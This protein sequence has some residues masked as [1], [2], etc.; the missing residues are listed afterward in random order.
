MMDDRSA[1]SEER[2]LREPPLPA[3]GDRSF[4][5]VLK[6]LRRRRGGADITA[7]RVLPPREGSYAPLPPDLHPRL[8]ERL[9]VTSVVVTHELEL[10]FDI[11][12]RVALLKHGRIVAQ[13]TA[14]V[15]QTSDHPDVRAFLDGTRDAGEGEEA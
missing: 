6:A 15:M 9:R 3:A 11:S 5:A 1:S 14:D 10:C 12:D 7:R 4:S 2:Q 8:Q 13:G